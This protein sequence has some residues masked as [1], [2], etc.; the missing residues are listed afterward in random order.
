MHFISQ[1]ATGRASHT[2]FIL[3]HR[4]TAVMSIL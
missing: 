2:N 4:N 3:L 1:N